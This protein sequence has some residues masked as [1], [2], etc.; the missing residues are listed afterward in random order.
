MTQA[1]LLGVNLH[2]PAFHEPPP[3]GLFIFSPNEKVADYNLK[4]R[5]TGI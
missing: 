3:G 4:Q 2:Q 1:L 5:L